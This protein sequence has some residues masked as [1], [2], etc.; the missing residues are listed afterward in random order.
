M[1]ACRLTIAILKL[2]TVLSLKLRSSNFFP[3]SRSFGFEFNL[4]IEVFAQGK[5]AESQHSCEGGCVLQ[6][7]TF[8]SMHDPI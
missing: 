2:S 4:K 6:N 7:E 3:V 1:G 5:L 8:A